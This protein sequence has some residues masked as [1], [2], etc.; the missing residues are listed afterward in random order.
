MRLGE[1]SIF[2]LQNLCQRFV[3][4]GVCISN[5]I[6]NS[7]RPLTDIPD[8]VLN[9]ELK[10]C[11]YTNTCTYCEYRHDG[12]KSK[13][14]CNGDFKA[15]DCIAFVPGGCIMCANKDDNNEECVSHRHTFD[16]CSCENYV[17]GV[18]N[19]KKD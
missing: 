11:M 3:D 6:C 19:Y 9:I 15:E 2:Q 1:L 7:N 16:Y 13:G 4:C 17:Y 12:G 10:P 5:E 8:S 14:R 18:E